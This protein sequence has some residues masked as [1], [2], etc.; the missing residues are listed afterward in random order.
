M[1]LTELDLSVLVALQKIGTPE[2]SGTIARQAG[3]R[4]MSPRET[5]ARHCIRLTKSGLALKSGTRMF[6]KWEITYEGR[7][8]LSELKP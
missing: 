7:A 3:I 4:T 2:T 1:K 5:A 8:A 6:P